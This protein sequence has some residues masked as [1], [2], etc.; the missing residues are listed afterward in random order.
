MIEG[1]LIFYIIAVVIVSVFTAIF[2]VF[3]LITSTLLP[4]A[5]VSN[6]LGYVIDVVSTALAIIPH[7][8]LF[9]SLVS[10]LYFG[11][12]QFLCFTLFLYSLDFYLGV[13]YEV[14]SL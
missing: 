14:C 6:Y 4:L 5:V 8:S 7:G 12:F 2:S 11:S 3:N 10:L 9:Y 1:G 13:R